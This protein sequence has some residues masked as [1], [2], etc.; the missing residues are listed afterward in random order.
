MS[1]QTVNNLLASSAGERTIRVVRGA[2][3]PFAP[4]PFRVVNFS[5]PGL[6]FR[7]ASPKKN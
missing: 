3:W 4:S 1:F 6:W 7:G 5:M 2:R